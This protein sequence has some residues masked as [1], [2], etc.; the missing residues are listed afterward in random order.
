VRRADHIHRG[1]IHGPSGM[2]VIENPGPR[3]LSQRDRP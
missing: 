2:T 1:R 3:S